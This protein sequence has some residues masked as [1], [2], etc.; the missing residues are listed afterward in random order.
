MIHKILPEL[1]DPDYRYFFFD[2]TSSFTNV[3]LNKTINIRLE[4]TYKEKFINTKLRK[5]TLKTL[6]KDCCP[7][8]ASSFNG[9]IRK[10]KD[11]VLMGSSLGPVLANIIMT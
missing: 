8:T 4:R 2:V 6:I 11:G 10:Q 9:N 5:N 1:F 7:K 3:P